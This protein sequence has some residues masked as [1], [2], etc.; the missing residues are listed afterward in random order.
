MVVEAVPV[1]VV[2]DHSLRTVTQERLCYKGVYGHHSTPLAAFLG[3]AH[4]QIPAC[5]HVWLQGVRLLSLS[6]DDFTDL[7]DGIARIALDGPE[8]VF[9]IHVRI[10]SGV[11]P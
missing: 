3:K 10:V 9:C 11:V 7:V 5:G 2:D 8:C 6:G 1:D 4:T